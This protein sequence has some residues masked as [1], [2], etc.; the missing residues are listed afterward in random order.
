MINLIYLSLATYAIT[1]VIAS[2]SLFEPL[3]EWIKPRTPRLKIGNHKH[4][5]ECRMCCGFW[6]AVA[7]CNLDWN[8]LLPV[9]GLSY[10]LA[11]QER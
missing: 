11:T 4:L 7:V 10:F 5:I 3:R 1:F 9:Y 8:M 2:S 6:C